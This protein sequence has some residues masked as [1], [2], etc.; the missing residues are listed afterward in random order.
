MDIEETELE[1]H[2]SARIHCFDCNRSI[3]YQDKNAIKKHIRKYNHKLLE[4]VRNNLEIKLL[5][6]EDEFI[7]NVSNINQYNNLPNSDKNI[8]LP[9]VVSTLIPIN[10]LSC[11]I[12]TST[13]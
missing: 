1:F 3:N 7:I 12:K 6:K 5:G 2:H 4:A 8:Y 11:N 9:Q 10:E 13:N